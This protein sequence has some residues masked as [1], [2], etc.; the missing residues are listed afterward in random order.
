MNNQPVIRPGRPD[1]DNRHYLPEELYH[2]D[3][4]VNENGNN[5]LPYPERLQ[6]FHEDLV[7]E[8]RTD[9]W[10]EYVPESYDA[11]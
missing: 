4:T 10:Y 6:E 8:G 3:I 9:T 2:S 7:G 1:D 5:S 11:S